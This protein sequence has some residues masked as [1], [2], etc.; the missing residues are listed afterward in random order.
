M[1][2]PPSGPWTRVDSGFDEGDA[3]SPYYD[4]LLAKVIVWAPTRD[5]ALARADR[6]LAE[7][8]V[9]GRGMA[10]TIPLLRR[11]LAHPAFE[12]TAR[13]P[14]DWRNRPVDQPQ[15]RYEA[16]A[17]GAGPPLFLIARRRV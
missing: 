13:G 5:E 4:S 2:R 10:T 6:A 15:T 12:W 8:A 7:F 17:L 1:F 3:V 9:E 14:A 16:K 11:L